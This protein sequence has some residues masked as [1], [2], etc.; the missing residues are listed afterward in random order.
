LSICDLHFHLNI[1]KKSKSHRDLW[2]RDQL[3]SIKTAGI[4]FLAST[5]HV[6]KDA[7]EAYICLK[8]IVRDLKVVIIPGVEWISKEKVEIIFLFPTQETLRCALKTLKPFSH[9]VWELQRLKNDWASIAIIPHP[10]TPGKTGAANI[11]GVDGFERLLNLTDYV[12]IYNGIGMQFH[13][14]YLFD[15]ISHYHQTLRNKVKNTAYLP[16]RFR[17]ESLGWSVGSDAHFPGELRAAGHVD[18]INPLDWFEALKRRLHFTVV[19]LPSAG[20]SEPRL[21]RNVRSL[22]SVMQEAWLKAKLKK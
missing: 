14:I 2:L 20:F 21:V 7:L 16:D 5:E 22:F 12:E 3:K 4:D 8:D 10:F 13:E 17:L 11:L 19:D 6:Y 9:S 1:Y 15:K 18:E